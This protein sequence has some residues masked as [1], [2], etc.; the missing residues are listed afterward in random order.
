MSG[1]HSS[2]KTVVVKYSDDN[3]TD[4]VHPNYLKGFKYVG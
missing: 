3:M 4:V 2:H 1:I